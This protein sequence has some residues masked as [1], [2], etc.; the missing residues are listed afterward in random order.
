MVPI[1]SLRIV[2]LS[3]GAF[4]GR[5]TVGVRIAHNSS[6]AASLPFAVG[7]AVDPIDLRCPQSLP[8]TPKVAYIRRK[9]NR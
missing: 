5:G 2:T 6:V 3:L 9:T 4:R 1:V 8:D 7:F